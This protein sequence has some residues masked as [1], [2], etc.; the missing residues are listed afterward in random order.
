MNTST[1]EEIRYANLLLLIEE[2]GGKENGQTTVARL[3]NTNRIYLNQIIN[4]Q[5]RSGSDLT[6]AVG[7]RLARK[8]EQGCGKPEGWMDVR[9]DPDEDELRS[10]FAMLGEH[11]RAALLEKA[12]EVL[13]TRKRKQA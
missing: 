6:A 2:N 8:L 13:K 10:I 7:S 11:G 5:T 1:I 12:R 4:R 9:H 3:C